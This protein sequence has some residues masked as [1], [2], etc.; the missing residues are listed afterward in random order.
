MKKLLLMLFL[1]AVGVSSAAAKNE[2][3][4]GIANSKPGLLIS[5]QIELDGSRCEVTKRDPSFM[6]V[7]G[8]DTLGN[9]SY[10]LMFF[11]DDAGSNHDII[12]EEG[13]KI[14]NAEG[15]EL[16]IPI[17]QV[18]KTETLDVIP[19]V[20]IPL[21]IYRTILECDMGPEAI[22]AFIEGS[23]VEYTFGLA[24]GDDLTYKLPVKDAERIRKEFTAAYGKLD[25]NYEKKAKKAKK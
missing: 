17:I 25:K 19:F 8:P 7:V 2:T 24:D 18:L 5:K 15:A 1:L 14:K 12:A 20:G 23:I 4:G 10:E 6:L 11:A 9:K 3:Y 16:Q 21:K 22:K 13:M